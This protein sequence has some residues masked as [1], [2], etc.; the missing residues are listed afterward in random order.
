MSIPVDSRLSRRSHP[1]G[2]NGFESECM[3]IFDGKVYQLAL[4]Q[5]ARLDRVTPRTY[6]Q[7]LYPYTKHPEAKSLAPGGTPCNCDT[8]GLLQRSSVV[9][10]SRRYVG[11]KTDRR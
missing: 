1:R 7:V 3:N 9:A 4:R 5:N 2:A 10:A 11:K 8:R 6:A